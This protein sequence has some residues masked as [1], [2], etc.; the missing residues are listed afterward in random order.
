MKKIIAAFFVGLMF[1]TGIG[2]A[3]TVNPASAVTADSAATALTIPYRDANGAFSAGVVTVTGVITSGPLQLATL[4]TT[5][6]SLRADPD[7]STFWAQES[8]GGV[9]VT[10]TYNLCRSSAPALASY[11]YIAVSTSAQAVVGAA[12]SN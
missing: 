1:A 3:I 5:Q 6:L 11:V 12:C 2:Y 8:V 4:T 10:N 9:L 7:G